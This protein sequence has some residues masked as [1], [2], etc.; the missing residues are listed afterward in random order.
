[1]SALGTERAAL[2]ETWA[3]L[4]ASSWPLLLFACRDL[5]VFFAIAAR[6]P[7]G[8]HEASQLMYLGL[9]YWLLPSVAALA[10]AQGLTSLLRPQATLTPLVA[11]AVLLPQVALAA[12]WARRAWLIRMTPQGEG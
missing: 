12:L 1:M 8:G 2:P 3:S 6:A 9:A 4:A 5:L 10:G 7:R 11:C